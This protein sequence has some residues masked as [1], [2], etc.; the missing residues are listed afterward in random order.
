VSIEAS[1]P[2]SD[3][4]AKCAD[5][6]DS[7][8]VIQTGSVNVE[9]PAT[10][11]LTYTAVDKS[12]NQATKIVR[13]VVVQD[14]LKPVIALKYGSQVL[15]KSKAADTGVRGEANPASKYIFMAEQ[16]SN[17]GYMIGAVAAVV[18]GIA[19]VAT[20]LRSSKE[21]NLGQLV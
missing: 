17:N 2:Y 18:A 3:A 13:K 16:V 11:Y 5:N 10:Y 15:H 21:A 4:G 1:F 14:T 19:L 20:N 8:K 12:K 9:K 6:I 7:V